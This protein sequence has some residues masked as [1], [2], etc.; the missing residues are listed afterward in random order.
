[1]HRCFVIGPIGNRLAPMNS[2]ARNVFE[3]A[4]EVLERVIT[5]ACERHGLEP[6]RAD[7][8]AVSGEITE[9]VFRHLRDDEVVI[10][11]LSG[12][13]ANVMYEL[14]VRHTTGKLTIHLGEFGQLPFD[15][16]AIRTIQFSRSERGLIDARKQLERALETGLAEGSDQVT[17]SRLWRALV[18]PTEDEEAESHEERPREET[19][20]EG[21]PVDVAPDEPG[22]LEQLQVIEESFPRVG[23]L[24]ER[25]GHLI[26]EIGGTTERAT[27]EVE[28]IN[29][30]GG[31]SAARLIVVGR[32]ADDLSGPA[33][34]LDEITRQFADE[35]ASL[36]GGMNGIV[37]YIRTNPEVLE[38][39]DTREFVETVVTMAGS[40]REGMEGLNTFG[41]A[42]AGLGSISR[43]LREPGRRISNAI[44]TMAKAMP[45]IDEW[46]RQLMSLTT[47]GSD[48]GSA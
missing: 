39:Q 13:N 35:L 7:Q 3:E 14:G 26:D 47:T 5:P 1:M 25:I 8:I 32:Y 12:G 31:T 36:D 23:E 18:R 10:A 21:M 41:T 17:V 48:R 37:Q 6:I 19:S 30:R 9:Q 11:D 46:E 2:P 20:E 16:Q 44:K 22:F 45:V 38:S 4:I 27:A 34:E 33:S 40:A 42:A 43:R 24:A 15:V 29:E 28:Q